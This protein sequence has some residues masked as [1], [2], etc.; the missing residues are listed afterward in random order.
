MS[1]MHKHN[2]L[3]FIETNLKSAMLEQYEQHQANVEETRELFCK[4]H[5]RLAAVRQEKERKRQEILGES[6]V[7]NRS[8][9][10][11]M[12]TIFRAGF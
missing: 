5:A 7:A 10:I 3:D 2:R 6:C 12:L 4:Y 1:Q 11:A 8:M 9:S